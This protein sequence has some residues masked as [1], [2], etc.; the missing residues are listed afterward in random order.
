M[1]N[2]IY[3]LTLQDL[4]YAKLDENWYKLQLFIAKMQGKQLYA[5]LPCKKI[6]IGKVFIL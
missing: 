1:K 6:C 5:Y 4:G 3:F 2:W